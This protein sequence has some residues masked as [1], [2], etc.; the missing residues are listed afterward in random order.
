VCVAVVILHAFSVLKEDSDD[1]VIFCVRENICIVCV[2]EATSIMSS[3][4]LYIVINQFS[5][6]VETRMV[7]LQLPLSCLSICAM[8]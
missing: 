7:L 6:I 5:F 1:S 2:S 3:L 8:K 4:D